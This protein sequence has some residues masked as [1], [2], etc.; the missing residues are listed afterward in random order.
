MAIIPQDLQEELI[1]IEYKLDQ[2]NLSMHDINLELS[3]TQQTSVL[4][5]RKVEDAKDLTEMKSIQE[6][7]TSPIQKI[8]ANI[9]HLQVRLLL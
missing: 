7:A 9:Q 8:K 4:W 2:A 3:E 5:R 6:A 1:E